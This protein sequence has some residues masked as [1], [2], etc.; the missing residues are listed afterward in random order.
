MY[1]FHEGFE[2]GDSDEKLAGVEAVLKELKVEALGFFGI[3]RPD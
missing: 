1:V 3:L 2:V